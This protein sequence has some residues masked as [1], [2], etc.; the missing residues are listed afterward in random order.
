MAIAVGVL[1]LLLIGY[2]AWR[3]RGGKGAHEILRNLRKQKRR[4]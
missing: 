3:L 1:S 2:S 4:K